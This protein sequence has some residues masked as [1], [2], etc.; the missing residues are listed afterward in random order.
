M[1]SLDPVSL[2]VD[3]TKLLQ[4]AALSN[5]FNPI[6]IDPIFAAGTALG[7]VIAHGTLS[8]NL[9]LESIE[10]KVGQ[11]CAGA[12]AIEA[13]FKHPVRIGDVMEAGGERQPDGSF[14]LWVRN[15]RGEAVIEG[16]AW[17]N[18]RGESE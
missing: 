16:S 4:Y 9:L 8:I 17:L 5:D 6:H 2:V 1:Q 14:R 7:G 12:Y 11:P 3:E 18:I 10:R 13:R 15:Q